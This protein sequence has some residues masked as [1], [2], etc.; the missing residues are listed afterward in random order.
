MMSQTPVQAQRPRQKATASVDVR[1]YTQVPKPDGRPMTRNQEFARFLDWAAKQYPGVL[2]SYG[3]MARAYFNK[4]CAESSKE[5]RIARESMQGIR[6]ILMATYGRSLVT[7][8]AGGARASIGNEDAVENTLKKLVRRGAAVD[9]S[10]AI[11]D[12]RVLEKGTF[13]RTAR[14][15]IA[16]SFAREVVKGVQASQHEKLLSSMNESTQ[17]LLEAARET[18]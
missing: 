9:R 16:Q 1:K 15:R 17:K 2:C 5:A 3:T 7:S 4:V 10:I 13:S 18:E 8:G 14:G 6:N 12:E 11:L